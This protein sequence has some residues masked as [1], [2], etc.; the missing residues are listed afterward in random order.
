VAGFR[1]AC[2]LFT[3]QS[4]NENILELLI[5]ISA[6]ATFLTTETNGFALWTAE[7]ADCAIGSLSL[8]AA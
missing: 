2:N 5:A 7:G 4:D 8:S 3:L 6:P 1:S